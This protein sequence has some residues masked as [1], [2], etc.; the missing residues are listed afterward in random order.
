MTSIEGRSNVRRMLNEDKSNTLRR[1]QTLHQQESRHTLRQATQQEQSQQR[2]WRHDDGV[3]KETEFPTPVR[4]TASRDTTGAKTA[5]NTTV[6]RGTG[7][8]KLPPSCSKVYSL[9]NSQEGQPMREKKI[10]LI[11][12]P[13]F[14]ISL[15]HNL[16]WGFIWKQA[17]RRQDSISETET[18]QVW[19]GN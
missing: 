10:L 16:N 14:R 9:P 7:A 15:F 2:Q 17:V 4:G 3:Q 19:M 12:V 18:T 11:S 13:L 1:L 6:N 5:V 8:D